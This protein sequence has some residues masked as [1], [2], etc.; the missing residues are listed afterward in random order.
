VGATCQWRFLPLRAP[1][2]SLC[3]VGPTCR[4]Q[5]LPPRAP[6]FPLCPTGPFYQTPSRCPVCPFSLST[7]WASPVSSALPAPAVDQ[8]ARTRAR[9]RD[10]RPRHSAHA[11][12]PFD[13]R[14]CPHSLPRLISHS[15]A[16]TRALLTLPDLAG[17]PRPPPRPSSSPETTPRHPELRPE[18]RHLCPCSVSPILLYCR[19]ISASPEFGR[20]GPPRP[21]GD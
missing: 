14:P 8:R 21:R 12:A 5:L 16:L 4:R 11:P 3:P 6:L 20:G 19:P 7:P 17:D 1:P 15:P 10:P 9:R 2:P 13:P 18:V